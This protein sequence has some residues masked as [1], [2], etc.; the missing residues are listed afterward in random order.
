M[1]YNYLMQFD[2]LPKSD[3]ET[4]ALRSEK[5]LIDAIR[6]LQTFG[7]IPVTGKIDSATARLIQQPRCGVGDKRSAY[8][9]SPD[10]LDHDIGY[11]VRVRRY[12]LQGPKWS[13]TDLTWSLVNRTMPEAEKIRRLVGRALAVWENNSK[14]TFRE[15]YSD[16]ADIQILFARLQHGDGY[17]F[18]GPGQVLA[19]AFYPGEGRG[20]DAHFDADET[21]NFD[22][23]ADDSH[24]TNFLNVA[25]HELGHSLGLGHSSD[26]NAVMFPW[27]QNNEVDG[28]L[29]DDDRNGIQELYG[30]KEKVWGPY[31]PN[32]T[33][34]PI[35][36]TTT[37]TT[38][39]RS[40]RYY[41]QTPRYPNRES[42][43]RQE[44]ERRMHRQREEEWRRQQREKQQQQERERREQERSERERAERERS[45]RERSERERSER[46]R[47]ER[48]RL[49]RERSDRE[50]LD[51]EMWERE[52]N[53]NRY[54]VPTTTTTSTTTTPRPIRTHTTNSNRNSHHHKPRKHKMDNCKISYDAISLIRGELF[55]FRKHVSCKVLQV[56]RIIVSTENFSVL[57]YVWRIGQKGLYNM[58]PT[59]TRRHWAALPQNLTKVDAVYE[60]KRGQIV[61]FVGKSIH[62]DINDCNLH[63]LT[64]SG[65]EYYVFNSVNLAP[66]YPKPL[67]SLGLPDTLSHIDAS[68]VWGHNN[69][70]YL[71]S[72]FQYWR[73]DD[74]TNQVELD[75]PRDMSIWSGVGY[76]I[77]AAF[78]YTDGKTYFFKNLGYWQFNDDRMRVAHAKALPSS[79]KWMQC[80]RNANEVDEE[81]W[82]ASLVSGESEEENEDGTGRSGSQP[83]QISLVLLLTRLL[84]AA[85]RSS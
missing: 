63:L 78:Q 60:N 40:L 25:L 4:G 48:E 79:H 6:S 31:R 17:K 12:V 37:T 72:G 84:Y 46:E 38:T 16:Q 58:Y 42:E 81:H 75:Y 45:E 18:D 59:E 74:A 53:R 23:N 62:E 49:D 57:Q 70:T 27:Y 55:I 19:H 77:D 7:N 9:F 54:P 67:T 65:R 2:Y 69:R 20:G 5:Q 50:R 43:T 56:L 51:R 15:V 11:S 35:T 80:V 22:G 83:L 85:I 30:S 13:K 28:K 52:R 66:G 8:D 26:Q 44:Y 47:L 29:P 36:T 61:F 73:L 33:P 82:T 41:P 10:N 34:R 39:M 64:H 71:T 3:L 1:Q 32:A 21:W 14:L 24:G 68:F 76:N